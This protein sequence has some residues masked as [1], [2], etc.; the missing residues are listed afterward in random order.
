MEIKVKNSGVAKLSSWKEPRGNLFVAEGDR[1]I[2][3]PIRRIYFMNNLEHAEFRGDHA[4]KALTQAIFAANGSFVL[5]LDD[6]ETKQ[7]VLLNNPEE[8]IILGPMLWH[9]MRQFSK[10]CVILVL[11]SDYYSESDYLRTYD[12]FLEFL[13]KS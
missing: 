7:E 2:P 3:F 11:A 4:H 6:G 9:N 12:Q 10:D 13:R 5:G 8:G 1:N